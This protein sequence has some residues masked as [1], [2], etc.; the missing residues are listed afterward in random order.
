MQYDAKGKLT[1][2]GAEQ[3]IRSGGSVSFGGRVITSVDKLPSDAEFARG[4]AAAERAARA[5]LEEQRRAIDAQLAGLPSPPLE[6]SAA[7]RQPAPDFGT[8][9]T[10]QAGPTHPAAQAAQAA[11]TAGTETAD[12]DGKSVRRHK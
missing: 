2:A 1:R 4:D 9:Q 10:Q 8:G 5:R 6:L 3:V 12:A 7:P 11:Q